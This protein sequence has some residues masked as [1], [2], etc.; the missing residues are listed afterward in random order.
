MS[1]VTAIVDEQQLVE[2]IQDLALQ[3]QVFFVLPKSARFQIILFLLCS[4]LFWSL[5]WSFAS[6]LKCI[7]LVLCIDVCLISNWAIRVC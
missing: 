6:L 7:P 2:A 1:S 4:S 5:S 3:D